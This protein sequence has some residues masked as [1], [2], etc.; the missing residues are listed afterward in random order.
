MRSAK[1]A[2]H[3][4]CGVRFYDWADGCFQ[5]NSKKFPIRHFW[6]G[7]LHNVVQYPDNFECP[8]LS[9]EQLVES[10]RFIDSTQY[11]CGLWTLSPY[12]TSYL[13]SQLDLTVKTLWHP[14]IQT[15]EFDCGEFKK[16]PRIFMI[17]YWMRNYNSIMKLNSSIPKYLI[18]K[19]DF[20]VDNSVKLMEFTSK[21]K[22]DELL[23]TSVVFLD[24][25]D[26]A[27]CTTIMEC[28]MSSTPVLVR[29]LPA[30]VDYLG[31]NYPWFYE[32]L[33]EAESKLSLVQEAHEY[34]KSMDKV[35]FSIDN[36]I[37]TIKS[38]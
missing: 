17:G 30:V 9:L 2:L 16:N 32:S 1:T 25:Y 19:S 20:N 26:V 4:P 21:D 36:F 33:E 27:A 31:E 38:N 29:K 35:K 28:I 37:E 18:N 11:C 6:Y 22:Y 34:L 15:T 10:D 3:D 14:G 13:N 5:K 24:F 12:T 23:K 7:I 8:L